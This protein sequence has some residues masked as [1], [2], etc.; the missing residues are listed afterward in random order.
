MHFEIVDESRYD[1]VLNYLRNHFHDEPLNVAVGLFKKGQTCQLLENY[2]MDTMRDGYS[3]IAIDPDTNKIAGAMLNAISS[4]GDPE[5]ELERMKC[6]D[7]IEFHRLMGLLLR[8]NSDA[9]LF[10]KYNVEKIFELRILSVDSDY[11]GRGLGQELVKRS[12]ELAREHGF[13]VL[14]VDATSFFTQ[15]ILEKFGFE[16]VKTVVYHDYRD[17]DGK[18]IYNTPPPHDT[19][20]IMTKVLSNEPVHV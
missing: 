19:Y 18:Y 4:L 13:T 10:R 11:R 5:L 14:K 12:E 20:K 1:E 8:H 15:K 16:T 7:D 9:Q 17:A 6:I 2:D 3:I